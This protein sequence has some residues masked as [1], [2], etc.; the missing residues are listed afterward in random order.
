MSQGPKKAAS[1]GK[2]PYKRPPSKRAAAAASRAS[3]LPDL[4]AAPN[5]V[6]LLQPTVAV[7][8]SQPAV[9]AQPPQPDVD[10]LQLQTTVNTLSAT[11]HV[12]AEALKYGPAGSTMLTSPAV[13]TMQTAPVILAAPTIPTVPATPWVHTI[14]AVST[15]PAA[16]STATGAALVP[17]AGNL[18]SSSQGVPSNLVP[19]IELVTPQ[20]RKDIL[21][22][23]D[24]NLATLLIPNYVENSQDRHMIVGADVIPLRPAPDQRTTRN[25]NVS[26]FIKSFSIYVNVICTVYP[27][28]R[29]E[30]DNY[31]R[32]IIEM[33]TR[34]PGSA[35]Y[36][37]HKVFSARCS[38]LLLNHNI[39][40]DW[41]TN[42]TNIYCAIFAGQRANTCASCHSTA[43]LTNFCPNPSTPA[44]SAPLS[45]TQYGASKQFNNRSKSTTDTYGRSRVFEGRQEVCNNFNAGHCSWPTCKFLHVCATCKKPSHGS[46]DCYSRPA[47]PQVPTTNKA[48]AATPTGPR[49]AKAPVSKLPSK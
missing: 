42:D 40:V 2:S 48:G 39:K 34:F 25:L 21:S 37:Y 20:Q 33:A 17:N 31:L 15:L 28:R 9:V 32:N 47:T 16:P 35:F 46:V 6:P 8:S 18:A 30:L 24:V 13:T 10:L 45:T 1:K 23:K 3:T 44:P 19:H 5:P 11:V 22:G 49:P 41:S 43:H 4:Q 7:S 26:E 38:S 29:Q 27:N 36:E 14:P 12:L